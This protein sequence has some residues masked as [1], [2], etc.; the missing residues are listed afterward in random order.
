V[1]ARR[2]QRTWRIIGENTAPEKARGPGTLGPAMITLP[3]HSPEAFEYVVAAP[4]GIELLV[5]PGFS[6]D[7]VRLD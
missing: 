1:R 6:P 7:E 4:D 3:F 5:R 2:V